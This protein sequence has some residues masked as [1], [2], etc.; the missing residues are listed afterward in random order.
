LIFL[1]KEWQ[2]EWG[3]QSE[4][5]EDPWDPDNQTI[6]TYEPIW[7]RLVLFETNERSWHGFP[8][9]RLP[10]DKKHVTRKSIAA[11][12]YTKTRP[13]EEIV[14]EHST[15]YVQRHIPKSVKPGQVLSEE[16]YAEIQRI[17][18]KRDVF[19]RIKQGKESAL[20]AKV[21]QQRGRIHQ[22]E[23][24]LRTASASSK[25]EPA[26]QRP[27]S[28]AFVSE[29]AAARQELDAMERTVREIL[30]ETPGDQAPF[31]G[32]VDVV[33]NDYVAGWAWAPLRAQARLPIVVSADG[34]VLG[35]TLARLARRDLVSAEKG[36]GCHAF[37]FR[38]PTESRIASGSVVTV[39]V[40]NTTHH[41]AKSPWTYKKQ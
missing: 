10:A 30:D 2:P 40:G 14:G 24:Q 13:P 16:D 1:N 29:D 5:A 39:T 6:K 34:R 11:Y 26:S 4:L 31:E 12:F 8:R 20:G 18:K 38:P 37:E 17:V 41:L 3:G 19:L 28:E 35:W 21:A 9:I 32:F 36:D 15:F 23:E 7:N 27:R 25:H 33:Q 22:L